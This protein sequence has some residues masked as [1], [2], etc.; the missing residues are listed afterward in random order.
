MAHELSRTS[1]T[2]KYAR[3][4][5]R[6]KSS[7]EI[8]RENRWESDQRIWNWLT[9]EISQLAWL[10]LFLSSHYGK[11]FRWND[12]SSSFFLHLLSFSCSLAVLRHQSLLFLGLFS[13]KFNK[14]LGTIRFHVFFGLHLFAFPPTPACLIF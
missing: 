1:P 2:D 12:N 14:S 13:S 4:R 8:G 10:P 5:A 11:Q 9:L 3:N 6:G 7:E